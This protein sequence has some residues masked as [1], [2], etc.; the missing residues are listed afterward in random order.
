MTSIYKGMVLWGLSLFLL[1]VELL[2]GLNLLF[3]LHSSVLKPDLDLS[4]GQA[5]LVCHFDP[6]SPR[7]VV[8][9]MELLFQL[10]SL[11]TGVSLT[12]S[13]PE[14]I[15]PREQMCTTCNTQTKKTWHYW[16]CSKLLIHS[17]WKSQKKS[18]STLRAKRATFSIWMD[19][20]SLKCQKC[21][22]WR[23]F[24]NLKLA[25]IQC[26]QTG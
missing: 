10:Q 18:H 24:E 15:S 11:V 3:E 5:K 17:V 25:V 14:A 26:Y 4:L 20:S 22:F 21:S 19:K 7:E 2:D 13:S 23:L 9:R 8:I 16:L 1:L 6:S 12:A